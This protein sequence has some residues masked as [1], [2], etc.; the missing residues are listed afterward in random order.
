MALIEAGKVS[1]ED[2]RKRKQGNCEGCPVLSNALKIR[3]IVIQPEERTRHLLDLQKLC[4]PTG[5][6]MDELPNIPAGSKSA[7]P[8]KI[9]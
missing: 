9:R 1:P 4:C 2:C 3:T 7:E 5:T 8:I 6:R